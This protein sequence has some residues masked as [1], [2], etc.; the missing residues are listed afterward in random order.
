MPWRS[1]SAAGGPSR[2]RRWS[3]RPARRSVGSP[4]LDGMELARVHFAEE[5]NPRIADKEI[6]EVV[7]EGHG[8]QVQCKVAAPDALLRPRP[9]RREAR[10][11]ADEA[12][13]RSSAVRKR[14]RSDRSIA[15]SEFVDQS[16]V[17]RR[18][19]SACSSATTSRHWRR[20][21]IVALEASPAIEV[22]AEARRRRGRASAQVQEAAPDVVWLGLRLA[23]LE[24]CAPDRRHP[25]ARAPAR[26]VVVAGPEDDDDLRCGRS[27][28]GPSASWAGRRRV[29]GRIGHRAGGL[30]PLRA[31]PGRPG[32][33]ARRPTPASAA[34]PGRCSSRCRHP[35]ST[36]ASARCSSQPGGRR[37]AG[38][39]S[40]DDLGLPLATVDR[41]GGRRGGSRCTAHGR[42][43]GGSVYA[44]RLST[45]STRAEPGRSRPPVGWSA[46]WEFSTRSSA[47]ARAA[48]CGP[49]RRSCPTST[50]S[51]PRCR[52]SPTTRSQAKTGEFRQRLDNG[53]TLDDL[54]IEAFAVTREAGRP[55]RSASATTTCS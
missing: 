10:A 42:T 40:A 35:R 41:P 55:G 30:G 8:H 22:M 17:V 1:R 27:G 23:G 51:S 24:R 26:V 47:P 21:L 16:E 34:R 14:D 54:L 20:Q 3:R 25:R 39:R 19:R 38:T 33:A 37:R 52:R 15:I 6:C 28:P 29:G 2:R 46:S 36:T 13:E 18:R 31:R 48:S 12:E 43:R 5:R 53:E 49:C 50:R 9:G 45:C 32:R 11:P 44:G 4:F 7:I